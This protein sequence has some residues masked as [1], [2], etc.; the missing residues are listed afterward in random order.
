M[1]APGEANESKRAGVQPFC[2]TIDRKAG[3]CLRRMYGAVDYS[4]VEDVTRLPLKVA[5]VYRRLTT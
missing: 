3:R 1:S 2:I 5:E 4:V